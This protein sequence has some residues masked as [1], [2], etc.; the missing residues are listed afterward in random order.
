MV[1]PRDECQVVIIVGATCVVAVATDMV[2]H[3]LGTTGL[4]AIV[5]LSVVRTVMSWFRC[6]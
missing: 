3:W 4:L 6:L 2:P 5:T 1:D